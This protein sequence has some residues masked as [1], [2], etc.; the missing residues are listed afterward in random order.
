MTNGPLTAPA[1]GNGVYAYG[2]SSLFPT[3]TYQ[4]TNYWVDVVFNPNGSAANQAPTAV[5]DTGPAV[6]KNTPSPSRRRRCSPTTPT[7]TAIP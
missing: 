2:G 7:R 1:S 4:S 6:T 3:N 5:N